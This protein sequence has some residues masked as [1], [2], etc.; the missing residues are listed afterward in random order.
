[1]AESVERTIG[2]LL[3]DVKNLSLEV[4]SLTEEVQGLRSD[5]DQRRGARK[6]FYALSG[7]IGGAAG[8]AGA[9]VKSLFIIGSQ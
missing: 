5:L 7:A 8:V 6:A 1:M 4:G 2:M 9:W 3:S